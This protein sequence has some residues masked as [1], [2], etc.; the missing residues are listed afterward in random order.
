[1]LCPGTCV[2][3]T[4]CCRSTL[5]LTPPETGTS[6]RLS[7]AIGLVTGGD[8]LVPPA[9]LSQPGSCINPL[10][11]SLT[12]RRWQAAPSRKEIAVIRPTPVGNSCPDTNQS[13]G[14]QISD[15]PG[16]TVRINNAC[17]LPDRTGS[18]LT[19]ITSYLCRVSGLMQS[20]ALDLMP[21]A[22][23]EGS[24]APLPVRSL[25]ARFQRSSGSGTGGRR[26]MMSVIW[27]EG[28]Y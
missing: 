22:K 5:R 27:I 16:S 15:R 12:A 18:S 6:C 9:S 2:S 3:T 19:D 14:Q 8:Y 24:I 10:S 11:P 21:A 1:M 4:A 28:R 23:M 20:V 25:R 13:H 26:D 7:G 17:C